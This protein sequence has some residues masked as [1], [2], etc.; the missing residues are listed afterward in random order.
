MQECYFSK[1]DYA[2]TNEEIDRYNILKKKKTE[3]N[4]K[5]VI[6]NRY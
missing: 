3:K 6:G 5:S 1:T 4:V 2:F